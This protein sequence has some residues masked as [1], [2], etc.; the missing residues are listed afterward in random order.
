MKG[1]FNII[2]SKRNTTNKRVERI[3]QFPCKKGDSKPLMDSFIDI[4]DNTY[5]TH[6]QSSKTSIIY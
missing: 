2:K 5:T 6:Y 1:S 3:V 4:L